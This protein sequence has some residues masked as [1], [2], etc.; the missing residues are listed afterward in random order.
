MKCLGTP[1]KGRQLCKFSKKTILWRESPHLFLRYL[2][3][4]PPSSRLSDRTSSLHTYLRDHFLG[5]SIVATQPGHY[6]KW[7][8]KQP[9]D[10]LSPLSKDVSSDNL[11]NIDAEHK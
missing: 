8:L 1:V 2:A 11:P 3:K 5:L 4:Y 7:P 6:V 9:Q 10:A